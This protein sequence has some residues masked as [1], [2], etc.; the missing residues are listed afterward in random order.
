MK[1]RSFLSLLAATFAVGLPPIERPTW[2][3]YRLDELDFV[4]AESAPQAQTY[5][6]GLSGVLVDLEH[7][8]EFDISHF[9]GQCFLD[10]FGFA[11][12][13]PIVEFIDAAIAEADG[14]PCVLWSCCP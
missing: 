12:D 3:I 4:A 8:Q 5:Y 2:R 9:A 6:L 14:M 1:R 10:E 7:I 11:T 13:R